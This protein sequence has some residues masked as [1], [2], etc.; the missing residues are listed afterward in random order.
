MT[1][2]TSEIKSG[3]KFELDPTSDCGLGIHAFCPT[4]E[5]AEALIDRVQSLGG[6]SLERD[7]RMVYCYADGGQWDEIVT[8][9]E[10]DGFEW[11]EV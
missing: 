11:T 6:H 10:D 8:E 4:D 9:L 3:I 1:I 5:A 2:L 7:D